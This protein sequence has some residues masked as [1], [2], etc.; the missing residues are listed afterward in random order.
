L[1]LSTIQEQHTGLQSD[2]VELTKQH[3]TIQNQLK[4]LEEE[5]K[6]VLTELDTLIG[7]KTNWDLQMRDKDREMKKMYDVVEVW[8]RKEEQRVQARTDQQKYRRLSAIES[9]RDPVVLDAEDVKEQ[10]EREMLEIQLDA[11]RTDLAAREDRI[12]ELEK[13]LEKERVQ[14]SEFCENEQVLETKIESMTASVRQ[15]EEKRVLVEEEK[16]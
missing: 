16:R 3:N 12:R 7:E 6:R 1:R 2:H 15:Q 8:R 10:T 13:N 9:T 5:H 4:R 14:I 11:A